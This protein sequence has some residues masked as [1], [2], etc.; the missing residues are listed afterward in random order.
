MSLMIGFIFLS[1]LS[2]WAYSI[3]N[4]YNDGVVKFSGFAYGMIFYLLLLSISILM[5]F[6]LRIYGKMIGDKPHSILKFSIP[7]A[8]LVFLFFN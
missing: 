5:N 1:G 2:V 3:L 7:F 4:Y 8:L 6:L